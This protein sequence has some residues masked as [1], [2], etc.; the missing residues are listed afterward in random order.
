MVKKSTAASRAAKRKK[1]QDPDRARLLP[2]DTITEGDLC[3]L[4][5]SKTALNPVPLELVGQTVLEVRERGLNLTFWRF[6]KA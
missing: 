3:N 5:G 1:D 4:K 2:S 6:A